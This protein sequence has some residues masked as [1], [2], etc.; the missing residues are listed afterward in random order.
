MIVGWTGSCGRGRRRGVAVAAVSTVV[1]LLAAS[2]VLAKT[3]WGRTADGGGVK[4]TITNGKVTFI[5]MT[6]LARCTN[7]SRVVEGP[8]FQ[9][10]FARPQNPTHLTTSYSGLV[11]EG[12][13]AGQ[14]LSAS[15]T[16][17]LHHGKITG[18]VTAGSVF[19]KTRVKCSSGPIAFHAP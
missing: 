7:G 11:G 8:G 16:A 1:F 4:A 10:P 2:S 5:A 3:V 6:V 14:I 18:T 15:F 13:L 17:T 9:G 19:I 12:R